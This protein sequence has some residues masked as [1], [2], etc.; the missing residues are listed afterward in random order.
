MSR[1]KIP[2]RYCHLANDVAC[3][4]LSP[5][6]IRKLT[7]Q[8]AISNDA[9]VPHSWPDMELASADW[10]TAFLKRRSTLSIR[11]AEATSLARSSSFNRV[12]VDAYFD[13]MCFINPKLSCRKTTAK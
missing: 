2:I 4:G 1:V 11:T 13:K 5:K 10:F 3:Y 6:D 8:L 9:Q 7:Y 12:N